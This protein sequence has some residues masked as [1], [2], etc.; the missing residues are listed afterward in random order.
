MVINNIKIVAL[1]KIIENGYIE[2]SGKK[3]KKV[4]KGNYVGTDSE[5]IDGKGSTEFGI[6]AVLADICKAVLYDEK[7]IMPVSTFVQGEY[8]QSG[9]YVG[10]PAIVGAEGV[11]SIVEIKLSEDERKQFNESCEIIKKYNIRAESI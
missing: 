1:N 4:G 6:G 11:E 10:V 9:F 2:I 3:I 8:G 5:I 7:R